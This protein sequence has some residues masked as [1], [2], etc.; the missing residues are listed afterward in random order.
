MGVDM[1]RAVEWYAL[2]TFLV[3]GTSHLLHPRAWVDVFEQLH[4]Q[5]VPGAFINGTIS[6]VTG[7]VFIAAHPV[8]SWPAVVLTVLGW[9]MVIKGTICFVLPHVA[10]RSMGSR[11]ASDGRSFVAAGVVCLGLAAFTGYILWAG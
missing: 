7:A 2:V 9:A 5:G 1:Q 10:L 8:W 11:A 4:R 6:L 3:I